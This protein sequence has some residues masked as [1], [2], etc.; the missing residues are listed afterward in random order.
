MARTLPLQIAREMRRDC[1]EPGGELFA[2]L[3]PRSMQIN[4]HESLFRD[5]RGLSFILKQAQ[6][7]LRKEG[8]LPQ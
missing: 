6:Q 2:S 8:R 4:A 1:I 7:E 3:E 5:V